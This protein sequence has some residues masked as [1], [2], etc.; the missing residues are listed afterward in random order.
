[1]EVT[2]PVVVVEVVSPS[3]R[4]ID[5]GAKLA[6]YFML[7]SVRHNLIVDTYK[8]VVIH[9]RRGEDGRIEARILRDGPL[10]LDPP[11]LAMDVGEIFYGL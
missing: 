1:M 10:T 2:N 5:A 4:G 8:R 7:P 3:R 9:H 11:G 6:S